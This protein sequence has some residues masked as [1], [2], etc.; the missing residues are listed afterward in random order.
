M[1]SK[2]KHDKCHTVKFN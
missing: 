2:I 1:I